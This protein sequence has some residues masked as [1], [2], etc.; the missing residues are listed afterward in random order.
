MS[1]GMMID[2]LV[3]SGIVLPWDYI[4]TKDLYLYISYVRNCNHSEKLRQCY[5]FTQT[6]SSIVTDGNY[7]W[8]VAPQMRD[9]QRL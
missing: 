2:R 1:C 3:P 6:I 8:S 5:N 9:T 4:V 7:G